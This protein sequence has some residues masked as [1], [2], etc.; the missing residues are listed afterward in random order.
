M[1]IITS[2]SREA[3]VQF[4]QGFSGQIQRDFS[5]TAGILPAFLPKHP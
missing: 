2:T 3:I 4:F 1:I 5:R